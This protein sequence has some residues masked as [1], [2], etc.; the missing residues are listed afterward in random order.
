[1]NHEFTLHTPEFVE[2]HRLT[3]GELTT[4]LYPDVFYNVDCAVPQKWVDAAY[5]RGFEDAAR[6]VVM[7]YPRHIAKE[8]GLVQNTVPFIGPVTTRGLEILCRIGS[9]G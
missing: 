3:K 5:D 7:V 6:H 2:R 9:C 1:M 4:Q 8:E